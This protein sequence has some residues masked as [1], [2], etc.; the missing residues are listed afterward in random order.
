MENKLEIGDKVIIRPRWQIQEKYR[1][2]TGEVLEKT[3]II[4]LYKVKTHDGLE[5]F[6]EHNEL[7]KIPEAL[8]NSVNYVYSIDGLA[9]S[10]AEEAMSHGVDVGVPIKVSTCSHDWETVELL[11]SIKENCKHCGIAKEKVK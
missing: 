11:M 5:N 6:F 2:T 1:A 8:D 3:P 4:D 10:S 9:F 7:E